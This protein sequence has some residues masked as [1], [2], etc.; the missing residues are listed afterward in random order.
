MVGESV[1]RICGCR[2]VIAE[3]VFGVNICSVGGV[4]VVDLDVFVL[5]LSCVEV[6]FRLWDGFLEVLGIV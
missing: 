6:K 3:V 2:G 1:V 4:C 5:T